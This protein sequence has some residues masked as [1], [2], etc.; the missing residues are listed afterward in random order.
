M[1]FLDSAGL[2]NLLI[3]Q[4]LA[5]ES[6][7]YLRVVNATGGPLRVLT[8]T[9]LLDVLNPHAGAN[10]STEVSGNQFR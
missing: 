7:T 3:A 4:R 2:N 9:G 8:I 6:G 1:T 5:T 10:I